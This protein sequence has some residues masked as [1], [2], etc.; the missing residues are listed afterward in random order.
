M[1]EQAYSIIA[2]CVTK[3]K[4]QDTQ[5]LSVIV[6]YTFLIDTHCPCLLMVNPAFYIMLYPNLGFNILQFLKNILIKNNFQSGKQL[7]IIHVFYVPQSRSI[8]IAFLWTCTYYS[9]L[10]TYFGKQNFRNVSVCSSLVNQSNADHSC[11]LNIMRHIQ[12]CRGGR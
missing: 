8:I 12:L 6:R 7:Q 4:T 1:C 11:H 9:L 3:L 2:I 5:A 10:F